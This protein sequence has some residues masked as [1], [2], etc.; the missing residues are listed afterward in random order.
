MFAFLA[1]PLVKWVAIAGAATV[2]IWY[3]S[4]QVKSALMTWNQMNKN[5]GEYQQKEKQNT[6][7]LNALQGL[8]TAKNIELLD[9]QV[10]F[11]KNETALNAIME[12]YDDV[13]QTLQEHQLNT[14]MVRKPGLMEGVYN[15]GTD[16][17]YRMREESRAAP[18]NHYITPRTELP[19]TIRIDPPETRAIGTGG[20]DDPSSN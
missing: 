19:N 9:M 1:S 13:N 3:G 10:K 12:R 11:V 15:R 20:V 5:I 18:Y 6:D 16:K 14:L 7:D 4:V 17:Y 8:L 2:A